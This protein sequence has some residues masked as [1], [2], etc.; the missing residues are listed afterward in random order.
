MRML[1]KDKAWVEVEVETMVSA[2]F[3]HLCLSTLMLLCW[4]G[5]QRGKR[6]RV[7]AN[8]NESTDQDTGE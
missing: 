1:Q 5:Q 7:S 8:T 3:L 4:V 2:R 6:R